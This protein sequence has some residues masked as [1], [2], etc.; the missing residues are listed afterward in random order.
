MANEV[1]YSCRAGWHGECISPVT[2]N[3]AAGVPGL[4]WYTCCC[5][6]EAETFEPSFVTVDTR[7]AEKANEDIRDQTSTG[8]KRAAALYPIPSLESGGME[9]EWAW[10][11]NAGGGAMGIVGCRG[12]IIAD[13]K[14][15]T[16]GPDGSTTYPGNIHHGPDKSTLNNNPD[17]IHRVC[18]VCHNRWHT[19]NDPLYGVRPDA[20]LSHFP[21]SGKFLEHDAV[22]QATTE[23]LDYQDIYWTLPKKRREAIPYRLEKN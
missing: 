20:G 15:K 22:T 1:C 17:N 7:R 9:C 12:N 8:R 5:H 14:E 13:I 21:L 10:L 3:D 11:A 16:T 18:P 6:Q 4:H 2:L 19:L 23:E